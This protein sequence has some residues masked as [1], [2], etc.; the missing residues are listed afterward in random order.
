MK[1]I[2]HEYSTESRIEKNKVDAAIALVSNAKKIARTMSASYNQK[3][4]AFESS[5]TSFHNTGSLD[6]SR[7]QNGDS[8]FDYFVIL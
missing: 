5:K 1:H 4:K 3:K 8:I 2:P 6:I 7:I